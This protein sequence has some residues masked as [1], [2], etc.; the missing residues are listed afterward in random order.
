MS[1]EFPGIS[2]PTAD[3][4]LASGTQPYRHRSWGCEFNHLDLF[5]GVKRNPKALVLVPRDQI[6]EAG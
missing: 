3:L 4:S 5:F 1:P 6:T 2:H